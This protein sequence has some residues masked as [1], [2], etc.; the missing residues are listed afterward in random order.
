MVELIL[1]MLVVV[2][3]V[4]W[5]VYAARSGALNDTPKFAAVFILGFLFFSLAALVMSGVSVFRLYDRHTIHTTWRLTD[6]VVLKNREVQWTRGVNPAV[7]AWDSRGQRWTDEAYGIETS[8]RFAAPTGFDRENTT[9]L[10]CT[11]N[12]DTWRDQLRFLAPGSRHPVYVNPWDGMTLWLKDDGPIRDSGPARA[13]H[14][15]FVLAA[16]GAI[17]FAVAR[18]IGAYGGRS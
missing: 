11:P 18:L 3:S 4:S 2:A 14:Q 6:A 15:G 1:T 7:Y 12:Q 5:Y 13:A 17:C 16:G 9:F 10:C 8:W